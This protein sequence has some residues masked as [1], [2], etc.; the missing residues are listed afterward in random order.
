M[1][2]FYAFGSPSQV[3]DGFSLYY[4][5]FYSDHD[6]LEPLEVLVP[7]FGAANYVKDCLALKY[8]TVSGVRFKSLIPFITQRLNPTSA[9]IKN[10]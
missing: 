7:D 2:D 10:S 3:V 6:I 1:I 4:Q 8:R 9:S 5:R